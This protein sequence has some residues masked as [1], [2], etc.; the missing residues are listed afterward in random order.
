MSIRLP[1]R[2]MR[3]VPG[4]CFA[5]LG[6]IACAPASVQAGCKSHVRVAGQTHFLGMDSLADLIVPQLEASN[7]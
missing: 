3:S 7:Q 2:T 1:K 6:I 5:L 4:V